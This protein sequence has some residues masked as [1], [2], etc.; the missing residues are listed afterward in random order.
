MIRFLK[1]KSQAIDNEKLIQ[2]SE[3]DTAIRKCKEFRPFR[4]YKVTIL[5]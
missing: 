2:K 1:L 5:M 4:N 3:I